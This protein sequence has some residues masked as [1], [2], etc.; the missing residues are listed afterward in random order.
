MVYPL[1]EESINENVEDGIQ[2]ANYRIYQQNDNGY[3][4]IYVGRVDLRED[5][6]LKDR[7]I[8]HL[9]DFEGNCYYEWNEASN[10]F[11]AYRRECS[12]YH[13]WGSVGKLENQKHPAKPAG[14]QKI[15]PVCGQ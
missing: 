7:M 1:N 11:D 14:N 8:E 5:Q 4:V 9:S 2:P 6:G 10:V 3:D 13:C 15:C 12:D